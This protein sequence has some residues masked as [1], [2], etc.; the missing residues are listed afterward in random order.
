MWYAAFQR[1]KSD[2]CLNHGFLFTSAVRQQFTAWVV[3]CCGDAAPLAA[4]PVPMWETK[5]APTSAVSG[6]FGAQFDSQIQPSEPSGSVC[7][8]SVT[9]EKKKRSGRVWGKIRSYYEPKCASQ[10]VLYWGCD[11]QQQSICA[12]RVAGYF[13]ALS[14]DSTSELRCVRIHC[15]RNHS[16]R[17]CIL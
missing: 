10:A 5:P 9:F 17:T 15:K 12:L 2:Q 13:G 14:L 11:H 4:A 7:A 6:E 1:A 16:P 8:M 3:L